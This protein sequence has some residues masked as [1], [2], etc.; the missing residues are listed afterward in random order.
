MV[1]W[2]RYSD[3]DLH[4]YVFFLNICASQQK[5]LATRKKKIPHAYPLYKELN[6]RPLKNMVK[7]IQ[8]K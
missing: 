6:P 1:G 8:F 4:A 5:C 2:I 3:D 7:T